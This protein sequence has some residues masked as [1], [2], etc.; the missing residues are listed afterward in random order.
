MKPLRIE[1]PHEFVRTAVRVR[2]ACSN[3]ERIA[4]IAM[5][6]KSRKRTGMK[7]KALSIVPILI[8]SPVIPDT[9][10][11][12]TNPRRTTSR[13]PPQFFKREEVFFRCCGSSR[14]TGMSVGF[15]PSLSIRALTRHLP[16]PWKASSTGREPLS[17]HRP[18]A[19]SRG[20][21]PR[22]LTPWLASLQAAV[23]VLDVGIDG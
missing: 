15:T 21:L 9:F 18:C 19:Q 7:Q 10:S 16:Q 23:S 14:V 1:E 8:T 13:T 17:A 22:T 20:G 12:A 4:L 2:R 11:V 6:L 3:A 5:N